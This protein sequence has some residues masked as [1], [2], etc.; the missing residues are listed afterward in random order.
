MP[1][2]AK[3][4]IGGRYMLA[5]PVCHGV[6]GPIW[7]GHDELLDREVAVIEISLRHRPDDAADM[8]KHIIREVRA[9]ARRRGPGEITVLDI[10]ERSDA[11]WIVTQAGD[12]EPLDAEITRIG[13]PPWQREAASEV[14]ADATAPDLA[15]SG[16]AGPSHDSVPR[17][18]A[19]VPQAAPPVPGPGDRGTSSLAA[20]LRANTA[21]TVGVVTGIA[22]IVALILVVA[23][24]PSH[25]KQSS[26]PGRPTVTPT[27][28]VSTP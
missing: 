3:D 7:R 27:A 8:V 26:P 18:G 12:G 16:T 23:L 25:P 6:L 13:Q 20:A 10:A 19:G 21:L 28:H 11:L 14:P 1:E 22:M 15:V 24:F 17:P 4:L 9:A 5:E 2:E